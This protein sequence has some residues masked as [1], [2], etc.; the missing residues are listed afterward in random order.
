MP[1]NLFWNWLKKE[2]NSLFLL[3]YAGGSGRYSI[4]LIGGVVVGEFG[5]KKLVLDAFFPSGT[6]KLIPVEIGRGNSVADSRLQ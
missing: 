6:Y 1:F 4:S 3:K 2:C 5:V